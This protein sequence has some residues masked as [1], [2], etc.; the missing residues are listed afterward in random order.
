ML[1]LLPKKRTAAMGQQQ[2]LKSLS[3]GQLESAITGHSID[4]LAASFGI[5]G[6]YRSTSQTRLGHL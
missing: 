5:L 1:Y 4:Y 2:P 6:E 3:P